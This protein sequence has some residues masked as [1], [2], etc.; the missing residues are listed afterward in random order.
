[1]PS[2]NAPQRLPE[3]TEVYVELECSYCGWSG[4]LARIDDHPAP[5]KG[6]IDPV[7]HHRL[8][9]IGQDLPG[10]KHALRRTKTGLGATQPRSGSILRRF[11]G[12]SFRRSEGVFDE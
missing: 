8:A 6:Q 10:T 9:V 5:C 12:R 7:F 4:P 11:A 2:S 3:G 1:M